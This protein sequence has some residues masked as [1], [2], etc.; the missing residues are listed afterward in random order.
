MRC[1]A[2]RKCYAH[3]PQAYSTT[4][5]CSLAGAS[6][7]REAASKD[8]DS[9]ERAERLVAIRNLEKKLLTDDMC[10]SFGNSN[11]IGS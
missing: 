6:V 8:E 5:S 4:V 10:M 1:D 3:L 7:A 11:F 9:L 2:M